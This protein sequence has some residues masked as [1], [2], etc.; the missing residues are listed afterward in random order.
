MEPKVSVLTTVY[1]REK[2][3]RECIESVQ[4][5]RFQD[6]EHIV[7]DDGST[8]SSQAIA[9][10]LAQGDARI[11]FHINPA[12]LGDYPNRN[13]AASFAKGEYLKY[14]DADDWQGRWALEVMVDAMDLFPEAG[15]GLFD[16]G[17]H[18]HPQPVQI[19]GEEAL[20]RY[21]SQSSRLFHRSPLNAMIRRSA[22]EAVGGFR[23]DRMVGDFDMWHR[24]AKQFSVVLFPNRM[25]LYRH[26][27][28]QETAVHSKDPLTGIRYTQVAL[29]H[30]NDETTPMTDSLRA[31]TKA[32]LLRQ[33]AR[34][35]LVHV[36]RGHWSAAK[37]VKQELGWS[38]ATIFENAR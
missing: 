14:L 20:R 21:Y 11:Q 26:H 16:D 32:R 13:R 4:A 27:G 8:D 15:W 38:W 12:N 28:D 33:L 24:L 9:A 3:L 30:L 25:N 22:F 1:N 23:E 31:E 10:D 6:Y 29:E 18:L 17:H 34:T 36:R 7:V 19:S 2:Y 5:G 37:A 35:I